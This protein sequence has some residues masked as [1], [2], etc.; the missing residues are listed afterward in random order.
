MTSIYVL[1]LVV[2]SATLILLGINVYLMTRPKKEQPDEKYLLMHQRLDAFRGA[3][4]AQ[5][6]KNRQSATQATLSVAQQVQSFTQGMTQIHENIKNVHDSMKNV[7][8][9]QEMFK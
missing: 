3:I 7:V 6:K 8:S 4:N 5:R 2:S 1:I 9:F